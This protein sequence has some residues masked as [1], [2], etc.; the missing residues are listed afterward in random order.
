MRIPHAVALMVLVHR[1]I[2]DALTI[3]RFARGVE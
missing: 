3:R 1:S 2:G